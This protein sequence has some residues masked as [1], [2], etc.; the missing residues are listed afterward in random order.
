VYLYRVIFPVNEK[1]EDGTGEY[2][3][4]GVKWDLEFMK[5]NALGSL[6]QILG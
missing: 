1:E 2:W 5:N 6:V 4:C 3:F